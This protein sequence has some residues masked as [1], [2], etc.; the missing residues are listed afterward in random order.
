MKTRIKQLYIFVT[1]LSVAILTACSGGGG[2]A[3]IGGSG[4]ISSGTVTGFGSVFIN[5]VEYETVSSTFDVDDVEGTQDDLRI[6]M[7]V[8]VQGSINSDGVTGTATHIQYADDLQG[9]VSN[10]ITSADF[11]TLTVLGKTVIVSATGSAFEGLNFSY[12]SVAQNNVIEVSGFYDELGHLQASYV[13][14]KSVTFDSSNVFEV[15]GVIS[16]LSGTTFEVQGITV[17]ASSASITDLSNGLQNDLLVEVKGFYNSGTFTINA[18]EVEAE[19]NELS[20]DGNKVEIE[21]FITRYVSNGDF[22]VNGYAVNANNA[23]L[24]PVTLEL[25][26]GVKVEAEGVISNGVLNAN[27]VEARGGNAEVSGIVQSANLD[28]NTFTV[29]L[30]SSLSPVTVQ[31][32]TSTLME[33]EVGDDDQLSLLE[34]RD[35][36]GFVSVR[37]FEGDTSASTINATRVKRESEVK[38]VELQ[39][40][41]TAQETDVSITVL[42]VVFPVS[43]VSTSYEDQNEITV[44]T[45]AEFEAITGINST[46]VSIVDK[47]EGDGNATGIADEVEIED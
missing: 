2:L 18:T 23:I 47:I 45:H 24:T 28:N 40:I 4:F 43:A 17:D 31:L 6:G 8:Q 44:D 30:H 16:N 1:A 35:E 26:V 36:G 25:K 3:G 14:L 41:V 20:E 5:G 34:L 10:I 12:D 9:P 38:D 42:G 32:S 46:V 15:K 27:E 13:E 29:E 33:D 22:D 19:D 11:K 39:G 7:V 37:G 21:G